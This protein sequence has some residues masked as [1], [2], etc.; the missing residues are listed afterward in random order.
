METLDWVVVGLY[1]TSVVGLAWWVIT[2]L[3][4][5]LRH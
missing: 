2:T 1:F 5:V 4:A 3:I